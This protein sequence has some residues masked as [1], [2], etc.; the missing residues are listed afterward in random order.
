MNP[1][2]EKQLSEALDLARENNDILRKMKRS[3]FWARVLRLSYFAII[4]GVSF[5]AYYFI[6]PYLEGVLGTYSSLLGGVESAG[7]SLPSMG[8]LLEDLRN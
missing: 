7:D 2:Q 8:Q 6:Q 4:L 5:G 3:M 1:E